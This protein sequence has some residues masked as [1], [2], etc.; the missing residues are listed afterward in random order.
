MKF[1]L[2]QSLG[3]PTR[4][5][6]DVYQSN[7]DLSKNTIEE[8]TRVRFSEEP[9][10][11]HPIPIDRNK[12]NITS[13]IQSFPN[14]RRP[15]DSSDDSDDE[16]IHTTHTNDKNACFLFDLGQAFY[17]G[18]SERSGQQIIGPPKGK[19]NDQR[20]SNVFDAARRQGARE[21]ADDNE[22]AAAPSRREPFPGTG[23][24]LSNKHE[25]Y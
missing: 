17:V 21:A 1:T 25:S 20:I 2:F 24:S 5:K 4:S 13:R 10:T 16:G 23:Y 8:G 18:G 12:S 15:V 14:W 22:E 11:V 9:P 7:D 19:D 3:E 6:H